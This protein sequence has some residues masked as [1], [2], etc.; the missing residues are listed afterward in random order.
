[1]D[2]A[3]A[4]SACG[5]GLNI[6]P[7]SVIFTNATAAKP[8]SQIV[9]LTNVG[10]C[11]E[12][13]ESI[14]V[15]SGEGVFSVDQAALP[16]GSTITSNESK[17]FTIRYNPVSGCVV[18][19]GAVTVKVA[20]S[21]TP[22][23]IGLSTKCEA[24]S[25]LVSYDG[26]EN[27][28]L[29]FTDVESGD[30]LTKVINILNEGPAVMKITGWWEVPQDPDGVNYTVKCEK[31]AE[32][33]GGLPT[34]LP[35]GPAAIKAGAS[36]D[37]MVTYKGSLNGLNASFV[38]TYENPD[39]QVLEVPMFGGK[40]KSCFDVAP[41]SAS[42]LVALDFIG[43]KSDDV[44]GSY[45]V[46]NCGNA[47]LTLSNVWLEDA[48]GQGQDSKYWTLSNP[49]AGDVEVGVG[50]VYIIDMVMNVQDQEIEPRG[51]MFIDYVDS[52][53]NPTTHGAVGL[54]GF[55]SPSETEPVADLTVL[56]GGSVALGT[57]ITLSAAGSEEGSSPISGYVYYL[58]DRPASSQL[59]VNGGLEPA[60]ALSITPD[61]AGDYE[62]AVRAVGGVEK[63]LSSTEVRASVTVT[64]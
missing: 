54:R 5:L 58:T 39:F 64:P 37:C 61:V 11:E 20:S 40:P 28:A 15:V 22:F 47:P 52:F 3:F 6:S 48:F 46:Y 59:I 60:D 10:T 50:G 18:E 42:S 53:G 1:M 43:A 45:V 29:D 33:E 21:L 34:P 32:S 63:Y 30:T 24:G 35:Q 16:N 51:S 8:D 26:Q 17:T 49:W 25:I 19:S 38:M 13:I 62:F 23:Q 55:V 57:S 44:T 31:P 56:E 4:P 41:G 2:I 14:N 12:Q 7:S 36:V 9:T 27:G